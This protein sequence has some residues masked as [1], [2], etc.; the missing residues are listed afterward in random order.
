MAR[1]LALFSIRGYETQAILKVRHFVPFQV[2][3]GWLCRI[4]SLLQK[5]HFCTADAETE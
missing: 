4:S 2:A 1:M 3:M 5:G